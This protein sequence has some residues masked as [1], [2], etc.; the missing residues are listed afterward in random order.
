RFMSLPSFTSA[1]LRIESP[2]HASTRAPDP[3]FITRTS[4]EGGPLV[5]CRLLVAG[6][7]GG[8]LVPVFGF[9]HPGGGVRHHSTASSTSPPS[10]ARVS[11]RCSS[12]F[13]SSGSCCSSFP[14]RTSWKALL[15]GGP[16][17]QPP[18]SGS[19]AQASND[20]VRGIIHADQRRP[21]DS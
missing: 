7:N 20:G 14:T 18:K 8:G 21:G 15:G 11:P 5:A 10:L 6:S 12:P 3:Q 16:V 19:N 13:T 4:D 9:S 2:A 17:S 1:K